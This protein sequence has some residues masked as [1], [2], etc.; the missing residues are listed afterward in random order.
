[1]INVLFC[2]KCAPGSVLYKGKCL[3]LCVPG[4]YEEEDECLPCGDP[5]R[6]GTCYPLK[7]SYCKECQIG[8]LSEGQCLD[9]CPEGTY[10]DDLTKTCK[11]CSTGCKICK[12]DN[13]CYDCYEGLFSR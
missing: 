5:D 7:P 4:T 1:M 9:S 2:T 8:Y 11:K 3:P 12:D 13:T 10:P 6:C